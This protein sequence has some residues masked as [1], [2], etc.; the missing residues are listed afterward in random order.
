MG[1][2]LWHGVPLSLPVGVFTSVR[3]LTHSLREPLMLA[4]KLEPRVLDFWVPVRG[5][6]TLPAEVSGPASV[7]GSGL[8]QPSS[9]TSVG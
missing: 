3:G 9:K 8:W 4:E 7:T 6:R 5:L 1:M 2:I